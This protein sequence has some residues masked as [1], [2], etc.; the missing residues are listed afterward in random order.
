MCFLEWLCFP[1]RKLLCGCIFYSLRRVSQVSSS[2][3]LQSIQTFDVQD[4]KTDDFEEV[5]V[6]IQ[7]IED[8]LVEGRSSEECHSSPGHP[9]VTEL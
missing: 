6:I 3:G 9:M 8:I 5:R 2:L 7:D 4:L 1:L